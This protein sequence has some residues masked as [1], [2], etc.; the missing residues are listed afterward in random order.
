[1]QFQTKSE[2]RQHIQSQRPSALPV[3]G[4]LKNLSQFL[5]AQKGSWAAFKALEGEPAIE[6]CLGTSIQWYFPRLHGEGLEFVKPTKWGKSRLGFQEPVAGDILPREKL[7]GFLVPGMA[8]SQKGQRVGRGKGFY[9]R[10]LDGVSGFKVGVCYSYQL[11]AELPVETH[12]VHMDV[13][14]SDQGITWLKR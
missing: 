9:D 3:G 2:V 11:F 10:A 6:G 8:F 7:D 5:N 14:V 13:V 12:D 1:M 4:V